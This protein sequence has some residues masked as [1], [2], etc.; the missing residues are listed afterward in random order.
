MNN[1][2]RNPPQPHFDVWL[3]ALQSGLISLGDLVAWADAQIL[4]LTEPPYWL[5]ELSLS[6]DMEGFFKA[7]S[8]AKP[9]EFCDQ[10]DPHQFSKKIQLGM[11]FECYLIGQL[12]INDLLLEAGKWVDP[13]RPSDVPE[14]E[15]FFAL[16]NEIE[17]AQTPDP[18]VIA[19]VHQ[20]FAPLHQLALLLL[21]LLPKRA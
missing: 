6:N 5:I 20:I 7:W 15:V 10:M 19:E 14:C 9:F 11:L 12:L 1:P 4:D 18:K 3:P 13:S 8:V 16:L 21:P 2:M 17:G